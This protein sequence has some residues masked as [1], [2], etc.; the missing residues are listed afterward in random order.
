MTFL[1]TLKIYLAYTDV[2]IFPSF[3]SYAFFY[4]FKVTFIIKSITDVSFYPPIDP[5]HSAFHFP[6]HH[7]LLP[8]PRPTTLLSIS[9]G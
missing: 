9:M 4:F 1:L 2:N 3:F 7:Q 6:P 8:H 5:L